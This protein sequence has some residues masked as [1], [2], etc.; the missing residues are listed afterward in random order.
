MFAGAKGPLLLQDVW[1]QEKL[2][3]FARE[4]ISER[5]VHAKGSGRLWYIH[6]NQ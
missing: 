1:F 5:V 2:A 4:R 6:C 3:H